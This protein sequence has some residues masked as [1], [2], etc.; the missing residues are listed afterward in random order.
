MKSYYLHAPYAERNKAKS[1]SCKWE[2]YVQLW[3]TTT[4]VEDYFHKWRLKDNQ[5][6]IEKSLL[7]KG[8][9][10]FSKRI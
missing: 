6:D 2:F 8:R 4:H 5:G 10:S 9:I 1:V 3:H 7:K